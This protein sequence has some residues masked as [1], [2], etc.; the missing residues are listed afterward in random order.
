MTLSESALAT[1]DAK[2]HKNL[3]QPVMLQHGLSNSADNWFLNGED[4][5]LGFHLVNQG[6]DVWL[7]NNRGV[8]YSKTHTNLTIT[9]YVYWQFSF[10]QMA[11]YDLPAFYKR[12]L[13]DYPARTKIIYM[14]HSE[15]TS[16][17]FAAGSWVN[18]K[19]ARLKSYIE[20]NT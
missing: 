7:G 17:M 8:K 14:G 2:Y 6:Y 11:E 9:D 20:A 10:D 18:E 4:G 1:L 3:G 5:S 19:W 16:Q 13:I 15:G 12:I